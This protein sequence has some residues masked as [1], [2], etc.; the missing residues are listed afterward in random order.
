MDLCQ[1][2]DLYDDWNGT[3]R[4]NDAELNT[5]LE[6]P[7]KEIG[8]KDGRFYDGN[9]MSKEVESFGFYDGTFCVRLKKED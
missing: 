1:L 3:T 4:I 9:L 5:I 2:L 7:T 8:F 6:A